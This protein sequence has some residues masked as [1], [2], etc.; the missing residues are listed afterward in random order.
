MMVRRSAEGTVDSVRD[1]GI[2]TLFIVGKFGMTIGK[3]IFY[4]IGGILL[5]FISIVGV[6][7]SLVGAV[8]MDGR[9]AAIRAQVESRRTASWRRSPSRRRPAPSTADEAAAARG[10]GAAGDALQRQR[11]RL[12]LQLGPGQHRPQRRPSRS[13]D[14]RHAVPRR[15]GDEEDL[16]LDDDPARPGGRRLHRV[17]LGPPRRDRARPEGRLLARLPRPWQWVINFGPAAW[18]TIHAMDR[19]AD[20]HHPALAGTPSRSGSGWSGSCWRAAS[21]DP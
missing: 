8:M 13:Q 19:G 16:R 21:R 9:R 7:I 17:P 10:G 14:R 15:R 11:L 5:A 1:L 2:I 18:T 3:R 12:R 20:G 4:L 6:Q